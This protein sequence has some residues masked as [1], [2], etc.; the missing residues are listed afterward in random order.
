MKKHKSSERNDE[1]VVVTR[2]VIKCGPSFYISIPPAFIRKHGI[3]KGER[4]PVLA[5]H[6]LK[7]IPMK[8]S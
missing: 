1:L 2:K 3:R 8:E 4:L 7:V 5:D 6:I